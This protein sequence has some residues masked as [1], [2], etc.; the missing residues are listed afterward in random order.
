MRSVQLPSLTGEEAGA[1]EAQTK[2]GFVPQKP[3]TAKRPVRRMPTIDELPA[4]AQNEL[5]AKGGAAP[6]V[7]LEAH[8]K[9]AGFFER[10]TG[11]SRKEAAPEVRREKEPSLEAQRPKPQAAP[12]PVA[13]RAP[14]S[15]Q[16]SKAQLVRQAGAAKPQAQASASAAGSKSEDDLEIPAFLRRQAN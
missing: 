5:R 3:A 14:E 12:Q 13:K 16:P 15:N 11:R 2:A 4:V 10:L 7:G 8:K 9:K 1:R 6:Q